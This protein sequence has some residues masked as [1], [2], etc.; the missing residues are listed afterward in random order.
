[1]YESIKMRYSHLIHESEILSASQ[2]LHSCQPDRLTDIH[3]VIS[4]FIVPFLYLS[5]VQYCTYATVYTVVF[6][7]V[8]VHKS[9]QNTDFKNDA[10]AGAGAVFAGR[11]S[12]SGNGK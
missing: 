6:T 8:P 7:W 1:M 5:T 10:L 9:T 4:H 3:F 11:P 12:D 2:I